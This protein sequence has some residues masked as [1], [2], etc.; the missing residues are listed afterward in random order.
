MK[1]LILIIVTALLAP[2]M[3]VGLFAVKLYSRF[4]HWLTREKR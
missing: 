1:L 3:I 2:F 4:W